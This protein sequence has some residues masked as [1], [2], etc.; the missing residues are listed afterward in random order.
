MSTS[1][2]VST[3][4]KF[5]TFGDL[6]RFLRR[7]AGITQMELSIAVGYS[8]AQISRLEQN[9]RLPD[10]PTIEARFVSALGLEEE[11]RAVSRLLELAA[12]IRREDAP[13]LGLCPYKGLNYFEEVDADLFVGREALTEKLIARVLSLT[14]SAL[15]NEGRF[16]AVVGASGSGKS[17]LVRAGLLPALRW[18]KS[19][20]DWNIHVFTP[21]S[22][23]LESLSASLTRDNNSVIP[24]TTLMDDLGRDSRSLQ[25]FAKRKLGRE[26]NVR[27]LLVIDQFEELFALCRSED[28]RTAFIDNLLTAAFEVNGPVI[29]LITLRADFYAHCANYPQLRKALA[30]NQE[31]MGAMSNDE[32]RRAVEEPARRGRWEFEPGLVDLLLHEVGREPG[33]LPLLSHALMETWQRRRG[34]MMT[35]SGY[36]SSGG[37][38]GAIAETAEAVFTDLFTREQR[39]I[40][41][42]IFLRLTELGDET[43]T[44]DTR[45]RAAFNELI[46]RPEET[47]TTRTVLKILADSRLIITREDG[48]EVAHEALIREWPTLRGWLEDNREGLRLHRHLTEA[49]Q[50]WDALGRVSDL[51]YRGTRLTQAYE[52]AVT[53]ENEINTLEREF[54]A[55]SIELREGESAEREAQRQRELEAAHKLA[56]SEKHRAEEQTHFA[57]QMS[58]RAKYLTGAFVIAL[59]MAFIALFFGSQARQTVVT[60]QN[61]RRIATARELASA[62]LNNLTVDPERSILLALQSVSTTRSVDGTVLPEAEEALHRSIVAS[63]IRLTLRGHETKVLSVAFS[64]DGK[65]LASIGDDGTVIVW[66]SATGA[67]LLRLSGS[68]KPNDLITE[69]RIEYSPDGKHLAACDSDQLKVYD[70]VTGKLMMVLSGHQGDVL[71]VTFSLDGKYLATGG[72]DTTVR[73]WDANTGDLLHVL[74]G[75]TAEVGGLAFSPD[76]KFLISTSE[77][78]MLKIWDVA[79]W[80][81]LRELSEFPIYKVSFNVDGTQLAAVTANGLQVWNIAPGSDDIVTF[82]ENHA[83][84][85]IPE[86]GSMIFSPDGTQLAAVSLSTASGNAIKLWD[87]A[88]GR[89][90][91]TLAGHTAWVMGIA[92]SQDGQRLASTSLDGTV[93]I[94]NLTPGQETI[95]VVSALTGYGTRVAFNPNGQEFATNGGDGTATIWNAQTGKPRLVLN[96]HDI[97]VLNVAFSADGKRFATG[98]LDATVVIWDT[99]SGQKLLTLIGHKVGV[100]DIAFSP[101]GSLIATGGFDSTAKIWDAKT[102]TVIHEITGHDGIVLGVAFSPDGTRL[103]TSS[104]DATAKI[105]DVKTGELLLTLTGH[106]AGLPDI[107]YSPDGTMLAT[108]SGDGTAILWD[109][110]TGVK[111][112]TLIGHSSQI[113]SVAFSPDGKLLAT[114][115]EDNTAKVWDV[116]TGEEILTLPGNVGGVKGVAFSPVADIPQLVV[117]SSDGVTRVFILP[118]NDLLALAQSRVTRSLTT[119]ECRKYLHTELCPVEIQ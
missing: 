96:G 79:T 61:D 53:H 77:D 44:G 64:P 37:V 41:R 100:R 58:K 115:S 36:T 49:S 51:L 20:A 97:E 75:H 70:P 93:K 33:A 23:P 21:T 92:L 50:E 102:G 17:S 98:S 113:Q 62:A 66:D 90:L 22:H 106:N 25:I 86:G 88:T 114:G 117:S 85:T 80:T 81:V 69:Q 1:I 101:D 13:S 78:A 15:P 35:L 94:W 65:H 10:I 26:N 116:A 14:Q 42:R 119:E 52:W 56:E 104:T 112:L 16:L 9:L 6:L 60:A 40:A 7:R 43:A 45:R 82:D 74:K 71:S 83:A 29:V 12:N 30:Q 57:G 108:G 19:S 46:L 4:E 103:A 73:I 111:L 8:D 27:L 68:T 38:R 105:W 31:Y 67:E 59:A 55:A 28:E 110:A 63:P 107:A 18:D 91:L 47:E 34:R 11:P 118:M 2:P 24:T 32:L 39:E 48:V 95:A 89:E 54:L 109:A 87:A 84:F 99:A 3:L 5:A 72:V 76:G